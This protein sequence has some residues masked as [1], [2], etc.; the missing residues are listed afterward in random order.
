MQILIVEDTDIKARRLAKCIKDLDPAIEVAHSPNAKEGIQRVLH[1]GIDVVL[2]DVLLPLDLT[3]DP[4]EDGSF[5]FLRELG[6]KGIAKMPL[7]VGTTQHADSLARAQDIFRDYLWTIVFVTETDSRWQRQLAHVVRFSKSIES[8]FGLWTTSSEP[9]DT[10]IVTALRIPEFDQVVDAL[11]G[12]DQLLIRETNESWLRSGITLKSGRQSTTVAACADEM[13]MCSMAALVTRICIACRPKKLVLCGIA[14]GNAAR[15]ALTDLIAIEETW[16]C[17]AGKI[18]ETGLAPDV[19]VQRCSHKLANAV[20]TTVTDDF[21]MKCWK[22]WSGDKPKQLPSLH[23]GAV[24]CSPAVVADGKSFAEFEDQKRKVLGVEMEAYGC[25]DAVHRLGD[26]AP[27]VIS[28]KSVCDLGDN[29]K[30]DRYQRYCAYLSAR[31]TVA[32]VHS[33]VFHST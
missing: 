5:W 31:A 15:V 14:G 9:V 22:D 20:R 2:L 19:K 3:T 10:A 18:T 28:I 8:K 11:G 24:A 16:D 25:Y 7:V 32:L 26:L 4:S 12:G 13:G 6:R 33:E 1:G 17:R 29:N 30:A 21:L 27:A 23:F